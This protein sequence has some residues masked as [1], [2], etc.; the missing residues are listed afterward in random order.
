MRPDPIAEFRRTLAGATF[1]NT[2][3]ADPP[4]RFPES[5]TGK[6][7]PE[8][9]RLSRN[10]HDDGGRDQRAPP[11]PDMTAKTAHLYLWVPN[12]AWPEGLAVLAAWGFEY[13]PKHRVAQGPQ[14]WRIGWARGVGYYFRNVTELVLFGVR[15]RN[16]RT[17]KPGRTQVNYLATRESARNTAAS[18]TK[19][20]RHHQG[21]QPGS[22]PRTVPCGAPGR[23]G[24]R[25][26][27]SRTIIRS[28]GTP[29]VTTASASARPPARWRPGAGLAVPLPASSARGGR[30]SQRAL[31]APASTSCSFSGASPARSVA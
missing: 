18:R 24:R 17:L 12:A 29:A 26:A 22:V 9:R 3:L 31:P 15:G 14:G 21:L 16:A 19:A 27:T 13:K 30:S 28:P 20:L 25:G 4:W 6:V 5:R 7:A 8:H 1:A 23:D 2:I 11:V 10:A